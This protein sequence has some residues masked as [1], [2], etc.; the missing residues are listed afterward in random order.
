MKRRAESS[1]KV[2]GPP[3]KR[4]QQG[5]ERTDWDESAIIFYQKFSAEIGVAALNAGARLANLKVT[6]DVVV[7]QA[8]A[9]AVRLGADF[10]QGFEDFEQ[11]DIG[12]ALRAAPAAGNSWR[13]RR[14]RRDACRAVRRTRRRAES[15]I[16]ADRDHRVRQARW[17]VCRRRRRDASAATLVAM[18]V[19][20]IGGQST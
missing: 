4:G 11:A 20:R 2:T 10:A 19:Q 14:K 17:S 5:T 18:L 16:S 12:R 3:R 1:C 13:R 6:F 9:L 7:A 8:P 15:R